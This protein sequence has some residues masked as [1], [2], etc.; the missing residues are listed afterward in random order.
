MRMSM[1]DPLHNYEEV[2]NKF[3]FLKNRIYIDFDLH[4]NANSNRYIDFVYFGCSRRNA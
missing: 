1:K 4:Q 3:N 2:K